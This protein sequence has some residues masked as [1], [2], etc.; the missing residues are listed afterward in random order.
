VFAPGE[1]EDL[2]RRY[3]QVAGFDPALVNGRPSLSV[4][5]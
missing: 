4:N 1:L 2:S 3:K 5:P